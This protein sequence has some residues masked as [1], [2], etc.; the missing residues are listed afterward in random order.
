[1]AATGTGALVQGTVQGGMVT[2]GRYE[3]GN[4]GRAVRTVSVESWIDLAKWGERGER[5]DLA[6]TG[7]RA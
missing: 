4:E 3:W 7:N 1:M 6:R 2:N 5:N